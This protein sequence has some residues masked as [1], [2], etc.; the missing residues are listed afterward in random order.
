MNVEYIILSVDWRKKIFA[1]PSNIKGID[2]ECLP[3][4]VNKKKTIGFLKNDKIST[5]KRIKDIERHR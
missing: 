3:I 5:N 2:N 1:V 4:Q